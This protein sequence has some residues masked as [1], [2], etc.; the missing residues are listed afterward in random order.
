MPGRIRAVTPLIPCLAVLASLLAP[1]YA[2]AHRLDAEVLALPGRKIQ[3]ESWFSDGYPAGGAKVQ[4]FGGQ[5]ELLAE[6]QLNDQGALIL[7]LGD[8]TPVRVVVSAG[9]GH[10]KEVAISPSA[11]ARAVAAG[12]TKN[13]LPAQ[14]KEAPLRPVP[15]TERGAEYRIKDLLVGIAFVLAVAA[16]FLSLRNA[17]KLRRLTDLGR[18]EN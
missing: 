16:F 1:A 10:R 18:R 15:V 2:C 11:F 8:T 5:G 13:D 3:V 17:Q 12:T 4:V 6:G 14:S 7:S 9:A